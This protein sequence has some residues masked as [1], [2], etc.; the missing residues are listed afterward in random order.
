ME[1]KQLK[2]FL[3][4]CETR[5]F[6]K[7]ACNLS[8]T[9]QA[10]SQ[11]IKNLEDEFN[12]ILFTRSKQGIL[13][14]DVA[15]VL[16]SEAAELIKN[17]DL[18]YQS[19]YEK[20]H[21][22]KGTIHIAIPPGVVNYIAPVIFP[23]FNRTYPDV[24]FDVTELDGLGCEQK[25]LD[26]EVD[27]AGCIQNVNLNLF[28]FTPIVKKSTYAVV[29]INN[30]LALKESIHFTD[31]EDV[32]ILSYYNSSRWTQNIANQCRKNGFEPNMKYLSSH[33]EVLV[34]LVKRDQGIA[35]LMKDIAESCKLDN[36]VLIPIDVSEDFYWQAGFIT[37]K[38]RTNK[39]I[40]DLLLQY[41][42][43]YFDCRGV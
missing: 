42:E 13:L 16:R 34:E 20:T 9:Q 43:E 24:K 33:T 10:L 18:F 3:Q 27:I 38:D 29:N 35:I 41:T 28:K 25:V 36:T 19:I 7:A 40:V 2:Y 37:R 5:S 8:L 6:S 11:S 32:N 26:D 1:V 17:Y 14:T 31:L 21:T 22:A 30:P 4:I 12:I 39:Y 23:F 15:E